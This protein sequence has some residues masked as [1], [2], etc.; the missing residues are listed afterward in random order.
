MPP[1]LP[2][3]TTDAV[4]SAQA[5]RIIAHRNGEIAGGV[6]VVAQGIAGLLEACTAKLSLPFAARRAWDIN[7]R[8]LREDYD[9]ETLAADADVFVSTG[10]EYVF[11][12]CDDIMCD[13]VRLYE[14]HVSGS[15]LPW[16]VVVLGLGYM[17]SLC[18][19]PTPDSAIASRERLAAITIALASS[20]CHYGISLPLLLP[21]QLAAPLA[22]KLAHN[23]TCPPARP[24]ARHS[25]IEAF[26]ACAAERANAAAANSRRGGGSSN[27]WSTA[28]RSPTASAGPQ[29]QTLSVSKRVAA[30]AGKQRARALVYPN[31]QA[32]SGRQVVTASREEFLDACTQRLRL[33]NRARK[34]YDLQ[35]R[36][37][38]D[39]TALEVCPEPLWLVI[40]REWERWR[41]A[42]PLLCFAALPLRDILPPPPSLHPSLAP[43]SQQLPCLL[44]L[45][46]RT[47]FAAM[48]R[49]P[50]HVPHI[51][52]SYLHL[53]QLTMPNAI[54]ILCC[55]TQSSPPP[56]GCSH[57]RSGQVLSGRFGQPSEKSPTPRVHSRSC[58]STSAA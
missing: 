48:G 13:C 7:G 56:P 18:W 24:P 19:A 16:P 15:R 51:M 9:V 31:G 41:C 47:A 25:Y 57:R 46:S 26:K 50:V 8:E 39:V 2:H 22:L 5:C 32:G 35:G 28:A 12:F 14:C 36:A 43:H 33:P 38:A 27:G 30:L 34:V 1:L 23:A 29:M 10:E 21:C 37:V 17:I 4:A 6:R 49:S 44:P 11:A 55:S 40:G 20:C 52:C 42:M 54:I 58:T 3:A 53:F 45:Y